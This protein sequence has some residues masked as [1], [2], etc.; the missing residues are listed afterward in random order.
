MALSVYILAFNEIE[1]IEDAIASVHWADEIVVIDGGSTDGTVERSREMGAVV[2]Y[3]P[4]RGFGASRNA[5]LLHVHGDWVLSIDSDERCTPEARAE[6]EQIVSD[7]T[8]ADVWFVPR[9]NWFFGRWIRHS[10]W[11]PDYRQPQLF[12]RGRM[13]YTEDVVHEGYELLD[14]ARVAHMRA[15]IWQIPFRNLAE[16]LHKANRY[17]SLGAQK[18]VDRGVR[19]SILKAVLHGLASFLRHY[20]IKL[21]VLDGRA[22]FLIACANLHGT[23]W[24]YVKLTEAQSEQSPPRVRPESRP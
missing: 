14:G 18:L 16:A 24:R 23:F 2:V 10:G 22:G 3:E 13:R 12:R 9:R 1:K 15:A 17:S 19:G 8:S 6:I 4:F 5:A 21:G 11:Y 7:P 20:V